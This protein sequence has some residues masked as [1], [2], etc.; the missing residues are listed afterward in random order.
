[1]GGENVIRLII[2]S[3]LIGL[4]PFALIW[5]IET[6]KLPRVANELMRKYK[7]SFPALISFLEQSK[8]YLNILWGTPREVLEAQ[9]IISRR[10]LD[11]AKELFIR[12][13]VL[14]WQPEAVRR[15]FGV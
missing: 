5:A 13:D 8:I 12:E 4:D 6:G 1:M 10:I 2:A 3:A 7:L 14:R 15:R 11:Y 9:G